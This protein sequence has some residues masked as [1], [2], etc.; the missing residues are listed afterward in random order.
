MLGYVYIIKN[1]IN[2]KIYV[3][4]TTR[5]IDVRLIEHSAKTSGCIAIRNAINK[6]GL[7]NFKIQSVFQANSL[8]ELNKKEQSLI[9]ELNSLSPNGYNLRVGGDS[10]A[11]S[12]E[13][14]KK[15]SLA[16]SGEN[17]PMF[18]KHCSEETKKRMS[19]AA[20]GKEKTDK[21]RKNISK[22]KMGIKRS[23]E[24]KEKISKGHLGKKKTD[25]TKKRMSDAWKGVPKPKSEEWCKNQ[26][27][28]MTGKTHSLES[29]V[30][31]SERKK[32]KIVCNQTGIMYP[33]IK[34][35]AI[36]IGCNIDSISRNLNG[37]T[38]SCK[39]LTFSILK[40]F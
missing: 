35:A 37:K 33:S 16:N 15:I 9:L 5:N 40:E 11:V 21:H 4:Q 39:G 12:E 23:E 10:S 7:D 24:T 25:E 36:D 13:T 31:M 19:E 30:K 17:H 26:S 2:S 6:H 20:K 14:A 22:S 28:K 27:Q 1:S 3:G 34:D 18:G 8:E 29:K 32:K 38:K